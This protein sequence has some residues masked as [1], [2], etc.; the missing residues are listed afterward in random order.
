MSEIIYQLFC[1][2]LWQFSLFFTLTNKLG[3]KILSKLLH[4]ETQVN[5]KLGE[6][7][8]VQMDASVKLKIGDCQGLNHTVWSVW[9]PN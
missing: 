8:G 3:H 5:V 1:G 6:C 7:N 2:F 9:H 4:P